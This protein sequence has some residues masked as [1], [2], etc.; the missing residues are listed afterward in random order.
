[1]CITQFRYVVIFDVVWYFAWLPLLL[2]LYF[3][4]DIFRHILRLG[5]PGSNS[6][7]DVFYRRGFTEI[8]LPVTESLVTKS[9]GLR[10]VG[11][12]LRVGFR[13]KKK[14][15]CDFLRYWSAF[16]TRTWVLPD[17][18]LSIRDQ[19]SICTRQSKFVRRKKRAPAPGVRMKKV[20]KILFCRCWS[21]RFIMVQCK[22]YNVIFIF[23]FAFFNNDWHFFE[24]WSTV[25][26][27]LYTDRWISSRN[28]YNSKNYI[29]N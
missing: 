13:S 8:F 28:L 16:S 15:P 1:M 27:H 5:L 3:F 17:S 24:N 11:S 23:D 22:K 12:P 14:R 18:F 29:T 20:R 26:Y 7:G 21:S 19:I 25:C 6:T 9:L 2:Y 10:D 4:I